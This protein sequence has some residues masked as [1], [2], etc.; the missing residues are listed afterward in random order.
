MAGEGGAEGENRVEGPRPQKL[1]FLED[2]SESGDET[3][4]RW[5]RRS[6]PTGESCCRRG[7]ANQGAG[8]LGFL[9]E[10][11]GD[12]I[13]GMG[14][15]ASNR[16][17]YLASPGPCAHAGC[18][19]CTKGRVGGGGIEGEPILTKHEIPSETRTTN[20]RSG[21]VPS[22]RGPTHLFRGGATWWG[23]GSRRDEAS[24]PGSER[25]DSG[26]PKPNPGAGTLAS[27]RG[28]WF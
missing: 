17:P 16:R 25:V 7:E 13:G 27:S 4:I 28:G 12:D 6:L 11:K 18:I 23:G 1:G 2:G 19:F 3:S 24:A 20:A 8:F 22:R 9:V 10:R 15:S 21:S 14:K 26:G 5:E